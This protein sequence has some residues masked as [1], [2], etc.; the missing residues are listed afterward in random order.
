MRFDIETFKYVFSPLPTRTCD[1]SCRPLEVSSHNHSCHEREWAARRRKQ[2]IPRALSSPLS[3]RLFPLAELLRSQQ[4]ENMKKVQK[5]E[6]L[7]KH[8]AAIT[9][10]SPLPNELVCSFSDSLEHWSFDYV[11]ITSGLVSRGEG[12]G[13]FVLFLR[14]KKKKM[15]LRFFWQ[16]WKIAVVLRAI[17][18]ILGT[19]EREE[20][21][22]G[23][24]LKMDEAEHSSVFARETSA[25][26][27]WLKYFFQVF[28]KRRS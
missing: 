10:S 1:K 4:K 3:L 27:F 13:T 5:R 2:H 11:T 21:K 7:R 28:E 8:G 14:K 15:K 23:H 20:E 25:K 6:N 9:I 12:R 17:F 18:Q 16:R 26:N 22:L 19:W 24:A